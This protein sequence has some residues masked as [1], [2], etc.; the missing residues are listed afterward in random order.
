MIEP[1]FDH[2]ARPEHFHGHTIRLDAIEPLGIFLHMKRRRAAQ[3]N[4]H[5]IGL[6]C[7]QLKLTVRIQRLR[8]RSVGQLHK[9]WLGSRRHVDLACAAIP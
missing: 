1:L 9:R 3:V 5:A 2:K 4:Q 7:H 8:Q 6:R